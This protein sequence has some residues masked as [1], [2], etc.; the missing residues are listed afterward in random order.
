MSDRDYRELLCY[1]LFMLVEESGHQSHT[2]TKKEINDWIIAF[3]NNSQEKFWDVD[4]DRLSE[5][6]IELLADLLRKFE[7]AWLQAI[8]DLGRY[9]SFH[10]VFR[11][12]E[13][14]LVKTIINDIE[15]ILEELCRTKSSR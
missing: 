5:G 8:D 15:T 14:Q 12:D 1:R 6:A 9:S 13:H 11:R 7:S 4:V 2:K 10:K 3:T